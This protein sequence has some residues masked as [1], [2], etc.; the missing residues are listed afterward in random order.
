MKM[1]FK[2]ACNV[3]A[4][5]QETERVA[6]NF[7]VFENWVKTLCWNFNFC[8]VSS[9]AVFT[10]WRVAVRWKLSAFRRNL[11]PEQERRR[12]FRNVGIFQ[13]KYTESHHRI[14]CYWQSS[15]V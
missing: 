2:V 9:Y 1:C 11:L 4:E 8:R 15:N 6:R 10:M 14:C 13:P 7:Y 12:F 5:G 3:Q